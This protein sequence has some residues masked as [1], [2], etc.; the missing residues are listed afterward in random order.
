MTVFLSLIWVSF[1]LSFQF[2]LH[3]QKFFFYVFLQPNV[4]CI[5]CF[6]LS[7]AFLF[8]PVMTCFFIMLL[9][10]KCKFRIFFPCYCHNVSVD[11]NSKHPF[12]YKFS[13]L[14]NLINCELFSQQMIPGNSNTYTVTEKRLDP[15]VL[16]TKIRIVPFSEHVRTV[17]MRVELLGYRWHGEWISP[18]SFNMI[19]IHTRLELLDI[20][21]QKV[22]WTC[23]S[24]NVLTSN[25][26]GAYECRW[27]G[28]YR[29][30]I[31]TES[32]NMFALFSCG[33][34]LCDVATLIS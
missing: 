2:H 25:A 11:F 22:N 1:L 4:L 33:W 12:S 14:L 26:C 5:L 16:A 17:C 28:N 32:V 9:R 10:E 3:V 30:L 21:A 20:V 29:K 7:Q 15:P 18:V 19:L 8:S 34:S 24:A 31:E 13:F 27:H 23:F 6:S